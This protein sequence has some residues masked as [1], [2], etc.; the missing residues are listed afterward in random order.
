MEPGEITRNRVVGH[1]TIETDHSVEEWGNYD[2]IRKG[3]T[4]YAGNVFRDEE[5]YRPILRCES[6]NAARAV[7]RSILLDL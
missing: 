4:I 7:Y 6:E 1:T 3:D 5:S 2:I